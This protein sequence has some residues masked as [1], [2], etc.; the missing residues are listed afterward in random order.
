MSHFTGWFHKIAYMPKVQVNDT[1]SCQYLS[2]AIVEVFVND[3]RTNSAAIKSN[4]AVLIK[5]PYRLGLGSTVISYKAG[6]V[7]TP[8]PWKTR[9]P[10]YSSVILS[11]RSQADIWLF[12]DLVLIT[13]KLAA[14]PHCCLRHWSCFLC[15]KGVKLGIKCLLSDLP[16]SISQGG[17]Y[18]KFYF[19][20]D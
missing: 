11:L 14:Y 15:G 2:Q 20:S 1:I 6:Y 9:M 7:L 3:K 12:E 17:A 5:V 8:P 13:G 4:T 16:P 19:G 18:R 10:I